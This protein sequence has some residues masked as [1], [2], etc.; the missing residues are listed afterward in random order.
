MSASLLFRAAGQRG[1]SYVT[2]TRRPPPP[3]AA[4]GQIS[5][6][7]TDEAYLLELGFSNL[8]SPTSNDDFLPLV[9]TLNGGD[10]I[11]HLCQ[12]GASP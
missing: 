6:L 11:G 1:F 10:Q 8:S 12:A 7:L 5:M 3:P 2:D 9:N 4:G